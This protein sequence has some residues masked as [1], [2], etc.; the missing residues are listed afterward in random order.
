MAKRESK[1]RNKTYDVNR[2]RYSQIT[3]MAKAQNE[4][5]DY[6]LDGHKELNKEFVDM[7]YG[8]T[9]KYSE[10]S[11]ALAAEYVENI[12]R[13]M[14]GEKGLLADKPAVPAETATY[15]EVS[16]AISVVGKENVLNTPQVVGRFVK[17]AGA[18]TVMLNGIERNAQFAW[19]PSGQET[20]AFCL[21]LAANGWVHISKKKFNKG[22]PHADHIHASCDCVYAL[23]FDEKTQVNGY[24]PQKYRDMA[25]EAIRQARAQGIDGNF[26]G[27]YGGTMNKD[28]IN[29]LRRMLYYDKMHPTPGF[30][31]EAVEKSIMSELNPLRTVLEYG[32]AN[33]IAYK[34]AAALKEALTPEQIVSKLC[35]WDKDGNCSSLALAYIANRGGLDVLDFRGGK[36]RMIFAYDRN[37]KCIVK[38]AGGETVKDTNDYKACHKLFELV[39]PD[40]EYYFATGRHAAIIKR[41][42]DEIQYLELQKSEEL[43]GWRTM[44]DKV[45]K[46]RF[47]AQ[48]THTIAGYKVEAESWLIDAD[49]LIGD[50]QFRLLVGYLNTDVDKQ[51]KGG[52][53]QYR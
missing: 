28:A 46:G 19:V 2:Y 1:E 35:G 47:K 4:M 27:T 13:K 36:N 38:Y 49:K 45:L 41:V 52:Y 25:D 6:V 16:K 48:K 12:A 18:D 39:R 9:T 14:A 17:Q 3:V 53:G 24:D 5:R 42:G 8:I 37:I 44:S 15:E 40:K 11:A 33:G 29:A 34:E 51:Q 23:R 30:N 50:D 43:S 22:N 20:C 26:Y 32:K 21:M 7:A 31:Y 10:A